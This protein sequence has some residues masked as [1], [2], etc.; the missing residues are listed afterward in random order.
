MPNEYPYTPDQW[1]MGYED[2]WL[3]T[4]DGLRLHA[5][6]M[7]PAHWDAAQRRAAPTVVFFQENA[8]NMAYR[9]GRGARDLQPQS[10]GAGRQTSVR[11]ALFQS[12]T[13]R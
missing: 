13:R 6:Y 4:P 12:C 11:G 5:W 1:G 10:D 7:W 9:W 2:V 8:G 3:T